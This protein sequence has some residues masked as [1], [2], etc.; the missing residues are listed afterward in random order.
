MTFDIGDLVRLSAAFSVNQQDTDPTT[1]TLKILTPNGVEASHVYGTDLAVVKDAV[2]HF[3]FD[4][5]VTMAGAHYYRWQ[6]TGNAQA[7]LEG[8]FY[9]QPSQF[10]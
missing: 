7:A 8:S 5:N 10:A 3:H 9:V 2:G 1:L 6:G 4:L